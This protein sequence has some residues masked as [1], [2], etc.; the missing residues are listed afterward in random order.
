[1]TTSLEDMKEGMSS[2]CGAPVYTDMEICS[3][4]KEHCGIE[5][6]EEDE[7]KLDSIE[8]AKDDMDDDSEDYPLTAP[9]NIPMGYAGQDL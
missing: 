7:A 3:D 1:M 4:C 8:K 6:E 9:D 2:C 5:Y